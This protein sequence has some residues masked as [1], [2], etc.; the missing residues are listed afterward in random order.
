MSSTY[1][2]RRANSIDFM[3]VVFNVP[4]VTRN[5]ATSSKF[6]V[7]NTKIFHTH[8]PVNCKILANNIKI[9]IIK[10]LW[11]TQ[12]KKRFFLSDPI[13]NE[14]LQSKEIKVSVQ[15]KRNH[16]STNDDDIDTDY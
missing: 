11:R 16:K 8:T 13:L 5:D 12:I 7:L 3:A 4:V 1:S 9:S 6:S 14:I 10:I 2:P 15:R